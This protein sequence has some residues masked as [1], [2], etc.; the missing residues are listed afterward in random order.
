MQYAE[1][2]VFRNSR[3]CRTHAAWFGS[4]STPDPPSPCLSSQPRDNCARGSLPGSLPDGSTT[5]EGGGVGGITSGAGRAAPGIGKAVGLGTGG[6]GAGPTQ[7]PRCFLESSQD[8]PSNDGRGGS[9]CL[10]AYPS[11][12]QASPHVALILGG[13]GLVAGRGREH[14]RT[15]KPGERIGVVVSRCHSCR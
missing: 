9:G 11:L 2:Q 7:S 4:R 6:D 5:R 12:A 10:I 3:C 14:G 13:D 1:G 8:G 15:N